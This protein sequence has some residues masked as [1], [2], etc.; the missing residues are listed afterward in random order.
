M[1]MERPRSTRRA[2]LPRRTWLAV[3]V[4]A[5]AAVPAPG[6]AQVRP[7]TVPR[8][9]VAGDTLLVPIPPEEVV[10]D[11]L[12][13]DSLL[14]TTPDSLL[15]APALPAFADPFPEG[16][17]HA[18][19]EWGPDE[20]RRFHGL[21]LLELLERVPGLI[22][23]RS[24]GFGRPAGVGFLDTGGGT[25]RFFRDGFELDP[26]VSATLDPQQ[27]A[28]GDL[29]SVRVERSPAE[30]RIELRTF[31]LD[32]RRPFSQ[33]EAGAGNFEAKLLRALFSRPI[34][35]RSTVTGA[36]DLTSTDGFTRSE[37][38][39][40]GSGRVRW[41]VALSERLGLEAEYRLASTDRESDLDRFP[42]DSLFRENS[43]RTELVVRGRAR[44]LPGL[45]VDG[46]VGRVTRSGSEEDDVG[47]TAEPGSRGLF[48]VDMAL[49]Q[50]ALRAGYHRDFGYLEASARLRG[51]DAAGT[52][53][54][55]ADLAARALFRPLPWLAAE[56][57]A[58][59]ARMDGG[60]ATR[61]SATGRAG[62]LRGLSV[63]AS[64]SSG[65]R[66]AGTVADSAEIRPREDSV[67]IGGV[68]QLAADTVV[69]PVYRARR[70]AASGF[71]AGAEWSAWGATL[72]AA[73]LSSAATETVPYGLAFDFEVPP[74]GVGAASGVEA[75]GS[76]PIPFWF[77]GL[78]LEGSYVN[79]METGGRPYLP[80]EQARV[81]L[82][83]HGVFVDGQ[84]EPTLRVE[85]LYRGSSI[86][87]SLDRSAFGAASEAY[88]LANAYL[89][90]RILDVRAFFLFENFLNAAGAAD[91]P[92]L[93][94]A[95]PR[96]LYGLRWHF[97]N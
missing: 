77:P 29:R 70:V 7:D 9:T 96:T 79:W 48:P 11:T 4:W 84:F 89:Q 37:P 92:G 13:A 51:G 12:P 63:F 1:R 26:L 91:L 65:E 93:P 52:L 95:G 43:T 33:V 41:T 3:L 82:E 40:F 14:E 83:F 10:S 71:R 5:L 72:G 27:I 94:L 15:A 57:E 39:A 80:L 87:P 31:E 28:L 17:A 97:R 22:V 20:L 45:V 61:L 55:S 16:F 24:G 38:F 8:D 44:L 56:A 81:G 32:D 74:V 30:T 66:W 62:P 58:R 86:A 34:G 85:G 73:Y 90:I 60:Q 2:S 78:R 35:G 88:S 69:F 49:T 23:T 25:V 64:V 54:P 47:G 76:V 59:S 21:S 19:W 75:Y 42:E 36:Y 53:L 18:R 6:A 67:T 68:R 46:Q 50:A